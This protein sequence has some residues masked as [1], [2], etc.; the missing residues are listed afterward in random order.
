[1][2]DGCG[3]TGTRRR[4]SRDRGRRPVGARARSDAPSRRGAEPAVRAR[5]LRRPRGARDAR[6]PDRGAAAP[7]DPRRRAARRRTRPVDARPRPP[8]RSRAGS[9]WT[10]TRSWPPR[11]TSCCAR[12]RI[13]A[14][15]TAR[16]G[17][18][19]PHRAPRRS[20]RTPAALDFR[21]EPPRRVGVPA[22][23]LGALA[24]QRGRRD[25]RRRAHLRRPV[26]GRAAA[27]S[28][29]STSAGCAA[30][31]PRPR[32]WSSR[33]ATSRVSGSPAARSPPAARDGSRCEDPSAPEQGPIAVRAG[34]EP[35]RSP[36]THRASA[37]TR[38]PPRA[39]TPSWSPRPTSTRP[40]SCCRPSG[41]RRSCAGSRD[42]D[43]IAIEDDYD[44]EYRYDRAAVKAL[45]GLDPGRVVYAGLGEQDARARAAHG[46]ADRPGGAAAGGARRR[47]SS[48]TRA[49]RASSS[50][51]WPTSSPRRARPAPAADAP[52]LP[53]PP[54]RPRRRARRRAA[55]RDGARHRRRPAPH[56]AP[57]RPRRRGGAARAR[58][59]A[60]RRAQHAQ[61]LL[62][63][64]RSPRTRRCSWATRRSRRP[65]WPPGCASS[66][67]RS[68]R[69]GGSRS[70]TRE[71][72]A[73]ATPRAPG[74]TGGW[75][76]SRSAAP[77]PGPRPAARRGRAASSRRCAAA[78]AGRRRRPARHRRRRVPACSARSPSSR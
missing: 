29:P 23:R 5:A 8:A 42:A 30:W 43:A 68:P 74:R 69:R 71:S 17:P 48:P 61:R 76:R 22:R 51:P 21:P 38:S 20:G 78:C 56:G 64:A 39:S 46:L 4:S 60:P 2:A 62:A 11:A 27:R 57:A 13:R 10:R 36:S 52:A 70:P 58:P 59:R 44:A 50:T 34:L 37:S 55:R 6:R 25:P 75:C 18:S 35:V 63:R 32:R 77:R 9:R 45:H 12:A 31:S 54:R 24:A 67:P 16:D 7:G 28:S 66:P 19:R 47:S 53:R 3:T 26:R 73:R 33:A 40:G 72:G 1:M 14:W 65:R 41:A 49:R 15:P